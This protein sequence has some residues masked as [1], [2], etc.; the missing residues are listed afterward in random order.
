MYMS[1]ICLVVEIQLFR[2]LCNGFGLNLSLEPGN[3]VDF[4]FVVENCVRITIENPSR[5]PCQSLFKKWSPLLFPNMRKTIW[6]RR[7]KQMHSEI[8]WR[9]WSASVVAAPVICHRNLAEQVCDS[10]QSRSLEPQQVDARSQI[11]AGSLLVD[12]VSAV[13]VCLAHGRRR[14]LGK[15]P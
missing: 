10:Q 11:D 5:S 14:S 9:C 7:W 13:I 6:M 1:M 2:K 3:K 15:S 4:D 12:C 8:S